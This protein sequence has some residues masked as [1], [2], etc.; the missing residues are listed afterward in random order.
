MKPVLRH[1]S[2]FWPLYLVFALFLAL[3]DPLAAGVAAV[4]TGEIQIGGKP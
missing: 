4:A 2:D 1:I 3:V